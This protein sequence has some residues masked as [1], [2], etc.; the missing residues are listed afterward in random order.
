VV[1]PEFTAQF[2]SAQAIAASTW[3]LPGLPRRPILLT[4]RV[5]WSKKRFDG[6][7]N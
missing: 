6:T 4:N 7:E 3:G 1:Y 5:A 2:G